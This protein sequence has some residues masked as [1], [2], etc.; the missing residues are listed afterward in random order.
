LS[1]A[2][3]ERLQKWSKAPAHELTSNNFNL[4]LR[5][6]LE[7]EAACRLHGLISSVK[8]SESTRM[9]LRRYGSLWNIAQMPN[10]YQQAIIDVL[11]A[12]TNGEELPES[13]APAATKVAVR[14]TGWLLDV[15]QSYPPPALLESF[16][17]D[18]VMFDPVVR[19]VV[20]LRAINRMSEADCSEMVISLFDWDV[21]AAE[22]ILL[23]WSDFRYPTSKEIYTA[24]VSTLSGMTAEEHWDSCLLRMRLTAIEHRLETGLA[25]GVE[26]IVDS[27]VPLFMLVEGVGL[28]SV[29]TGVINLPEERHA[30]FLALAHR[31]RD[32][33]L[34]D[35]LF[36]DG[37]FA[38]F[39][40]RS[41]TC[42]GRTPLCST[43]LKALNDLP[44]ENVCGVRS[45]LH[46][47]GFF[48]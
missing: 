7:G 34:F 16:G 22:D 42:D 2:A 39:Y 41:H 45:Q 10:A 18:A 35:L 43:G 15:V 11:A 32:L 6:I 44:P 29:Q 46:E 12:I 14:L 1:E 27:G 3:V 5:H 23:R 47:A 4:G 19:F 17:D 13:S 28:E 9:E 21:W 30:Y 38:C 25:K 33:E 40:G 26:H 36:A 8:C 24:W 48:I 31:Y 20:F 37:K